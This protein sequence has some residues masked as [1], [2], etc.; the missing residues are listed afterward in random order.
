VAADGFR[1][2][3]QAQPVDF[4]IPITMQQVGR[5]RG[6]T[7]DRRGWGWL[8]LVGRRE[9]A[10]TLEV[11]Q[12]QLDAA[13]DDLSRR[14]PPR[15]AAAAVGFHAQPAGAITESERA[16]VMPTLTVLLAFTGLL[17]IVTCANLAGLMQ[18][19]ILARR[20]EMAVRESLG[21][22]RGRLVSAWLT[23]CLLVALG[24]GALGLLTARLAVVWIGGVRPPEQLVGRVSL[25]S[26]FDW[27]VT[28]YA[29]GL[30]IAAAV[31]FGLL[32]AWRTVWGSTS[33]WLRDESRSAGGSRATAVIRRTTVV[34]QLAVSGVLLLAATLLGESVFRQ[35]AVDPGFDTSRLAVLTIDFDRQRVP[36]AERSGLLAASRER[37]RRD[38][39]VRAAE[40]AMSVPLGFGDDVMGFRIDGHVP[41]D[42]RDYV[43]IDFNVV[44]AG[45][46]EALGAPLVSGRPWAADLS[47]GAA[48]VV[49]INETMARRFWNDRDPVGQSIGIVPN[50]RATIVGVVRDVAYYEIGADPIPY[51]YLP[52]ELR[53]PGRVILH[54]R[55]AGDPGPVIARLAKAIETVDP[56]LAATEV[57]TFEELRRVPL[58][59]PRLLAIAASVFGGLSVLLAGVGLFGVVTMSVGERTREIGVRMALGARPDVVLRGVLGEAML[60]AGLGLV[61]ALV[62]G[63]LGSGVLSAW[64]FQ[65]SPFDVS[66]YG[67]VVVLLVGLALLAAWVP[68]RRAARIVPVTALRQG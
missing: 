24:G 27:S 54:V 8:R 6:L 17:F 52:A 25:A 44:G 36:E 11:V 59:T 65:T 49:V 16:V 13:A 10:G 42:G 40:G 29:L 48:P 39:D 28:L 61:L 21:A 66:A 64:L 35:T 41:A 50:G 38:P 30:S 43:L 9:V 47:P 53:P 31:V 23:E 12:A 34:A 67:L 4:W 20:R 62:A 45:Y 33:G 46:F 3:F 63:Y 15:S 57:M 58:F 1:G 19:R 32:P 68:A 5:P 18:A 2:T 60:L 51:L 22:G 37:I 14:E 26:S 55:T 7:I 56:R